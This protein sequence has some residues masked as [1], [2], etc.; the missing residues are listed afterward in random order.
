ML[1]AVSLLCFRSLK[2][3]VAAKGLVRLNL[4]GNTL[5]TRPRFVHQ[6]RFFLSIDRN[7]LGIFKTKTFLSRWRPRL[8]LLSSIC[9]GLKDYIAGFELNVYYLLFWLLPVPVQL[10]F[11]IHPW[12]CFG[13][14]SGVRWKIFTKILPKMNWS[15]FGGKMTSGRWRHTEPDAVHSFHS[16]IS[17]LQQMSKRIRRY[18]WLKHITI[19]LLGK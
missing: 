14:V 19:M 17:L 13:N 16:F 6:V 9:L 15:W 5:C 11:V 12:R 7:S 1:V 2:G 4:L 3:L 18:M 8:F 10:V